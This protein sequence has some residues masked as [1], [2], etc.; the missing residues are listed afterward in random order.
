MTGLKIVDTDGDT[1][2]GI[3][4]VW[5][6]C[7]RAL[8]HEYGIV[9][10]GILDTGVA[11]CLARAQHPNKARY[12][13]QLNRARETPSRKGAREHTR[14]SSNEPTERAHTHTTR[15]AA[16]RP[17]GAVPRAGGASWGRRLSSPPAYLA[18]H[19]QQRYLISQQHTPWGGR[20][21]EPAGGCRR[22]SLRP[23]T[24]QQ[25]LWHPG[26]R[27]LPRLAPSL[28][29]AARRA[30]CPRIRVPARAA[31]CSKWALYPHITPTAR[32]SGPP[33]PKQLSGMSALR[34]SS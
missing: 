7:E 32:A 2:I 20:D 30:V 21:G 14:E 4:H 10:R 33:A 8:F 3:L 27:R 19:P 25:I 23:W 11:D 22:Q 28:C 31:I 16:T 26:R 29:T 12:M 34:T 1:H 15:R 24:P 6:H 9:T 13:G 5:R 18:A 17:R